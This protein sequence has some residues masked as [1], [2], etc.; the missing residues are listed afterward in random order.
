MREIEIKAR[1]KNLA[2]LK[3]N[4]ESK[5]IIFGPSLK[6]KDVSYG[7]P[8]VAGAAPGSVWLRIR[9]ENDHKITFT[10]K[11]PVGGELDNIEHETEVSNAKELESIINYLGYEIHS[12]LTKV[13]HKALYKD[14]EI[15]LDSVDGLGDF[16]E[17]EKLV[18][19]DFAYDEVK[20]E[21][22]ELFDELGISK[23][24]EVTVGYDILERRKRGV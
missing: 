24:D 19:D 11:K 7:W 22:W 18:E 9:A 6:Q 15:C 21:L 4:L 1:V 14:I 8:G 13:R 10:L 5:G 20:Q 23:N 12:E 16:I 17:A 3:Q 2:K